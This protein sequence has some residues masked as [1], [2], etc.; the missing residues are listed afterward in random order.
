MTS[1]PAAMLDEFRRTADA[2]T[3]T[4]F[5]LRHRAD[6]KIEIG[7]HWKTGL[8]TFCNPCAHVQH[9]VWTAR[10][11]LVAVPDCR[12]DHARVIIGSVENF[13]EDVGW[14]IKRGYWIDHRIVRE[15]GVGGITEQLREWFPRLHYGQ[16]GDMREHIDRTCRPAATAGWSRGSYFWK[17]D[18]AKA[19]RS[20]ARAR[21]RARCLWCR[22]IFPW[23]NYRV[24]CDLGCRV[25]HQRDEEKRERQQRRE[26]EW[27]RRG[28]QTLQQI[29]KTLRQQGQG[30]PSPQRE[31]S[32]QDTTS[33]T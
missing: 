14:S 8:P 17:R 2:C 4:P 27:L 15:S 5:E 33:Q 9:I 16:L 32:R 3:W 29:K 24:Y 20:H 1:D 12:H 23:A 25:E 26:L 22:K 21:G 28:K 30:A 31:A 13:S 11:Y 7:K 19:I 10:D 6:C 18:I